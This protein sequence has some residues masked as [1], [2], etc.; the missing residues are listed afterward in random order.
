MDKSVI[1]KYFFLEETMRQVSE[2]S[3]DVAQDY[4]KSRQNML[5]RTFVS[6]SD[7]AASKVAKTQKTSELHQKEAPNSAEDT[8]ISAKRKN[9]NDEPS[10]KK[11]P[12]DQILHNVIIMNQNLEQTSLEYARMNLGKF[13][14]IMIEENGQWK[15]KLLIN[16]LFIVESELSPVQKSAKK[17]MTIKALEVL[18]K[19][20]YKI[21]VSMNFCRKR[22]P[23]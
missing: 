3:K 17:D 8:K 23:K 12:L 20:C 7:A 13:E 15:A 5:K 14:T 9:S 10:K 19:K 22:P 16:S 2:L 6:A 18:N 11:T 1:F 21:N 4:R